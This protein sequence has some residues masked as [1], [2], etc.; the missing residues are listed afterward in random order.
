[1]CMSK[2]QIILYSFCVTNK[3]SQKLKKENGKTL[4]LLAAATYNAEEQLDATIGKGF[5]AMKNSLQ[6]IMCTS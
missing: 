1:M 4:T 5:S 3:N 2:S 6:E